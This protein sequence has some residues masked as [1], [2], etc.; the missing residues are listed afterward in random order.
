MSRE[1]I[2]NALPILLT[3]DETARIL[4]VSIQR[5][6]QLARENAFPTVRVGRQVRVDPR[7]LEDWINAGGKSLP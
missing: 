5:A 3:I 4:N 2:K 7:A 1:N 6:Y